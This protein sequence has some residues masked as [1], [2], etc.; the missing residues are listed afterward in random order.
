MFR[1]ML[2]VKTLL[3]KE[4]Y[5][6]LWLPCKMIFFLYPWR[7]HVQLFDVYLFPSLL[8][9]TI[10]HFLQSLTNFDRYPEQE[11][12]FVTSVSFLTIECDDLV[13]DVPQEHTL[14]LKSLASAHRVEQT[15]THN[16]GARKRVQFPTVAQL[17]QSDHL[18]SKR[19][20]FPLCSHEALHITLQIT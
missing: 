16:S 18:Q 9:V 14:F 11:V 10:V 1:V 4:I 20:L 7:S 6:P 5:L 8:K 13:R 19:L 2:W 3:W 15:A 17:S 12:F